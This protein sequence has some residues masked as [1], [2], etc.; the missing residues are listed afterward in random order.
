[1]TR[2]EAKAFIK[3]Q[4]EGY[5]KDKGIDTRRPFNCLNP[6]H[7]DKN[8]SMSLDREHNQAHCFSCGAK[9][10][11][12]DLIGMDNHLDPAR[13]FQRAYERYGI[14]LEGS[15]SPQKPITANK[16]KTPYQESETPPRP[17]TEG[18]NY[19]EY[20]AKCK[21]ALKSSPEALAYLQGRGLTGVSNRL[22][23]D[24]EKKLLI[25]PYDAAGNYYISRSI[26][27]KEYRKAPGQEPLYNAEALYNGSGAVFITEG[28]LD[29]LSII[30]AG[31]EAVA[32]NGTAYTKLLTQLE[33]RRTNNTLIIALDN[34]EAGRAASKKL[35]GELEARRIDYMTVNI[36]GGKKD[37]NE[38]L[39]AD[40][41]QLEGA[42]KDVIEGIEA[43][44]QAQRE[45]EIEEYKQENSAYSHIQAFLEG[46]KIDTPAIPT[47][48]K[49][50]D[51]ALDGGLYEGLYVLG[52]ISSLGKT[53]LVL[54]IAD[55]IAQQGNDVLI[56][57]LEMAR[58]ELMAKSIS[59]ITF[60]GCNGKPSNAK[61]TRGITARQRHE[62]YSTEEKRLINESIVRYG[63]YA[64]N[65]Y[66]SEGAGNI[67]AEEIGEAVRKHISITGKKP[68]VVI[69]YLQILKAA[70]P[71]ST[72]KQN[73]DKA[74]FMLKRIS[75]EYKIPIIGIS[76]LNRDNYKQ[77]INM[78][79]FKESGAIE[80]S[81]DV[82]IG[83][84]FQEVND[85]EISEE[86][87]D[88]EKRKDTR[89]IELK[90]LKNRNGQTGDQIDY[91]FISMFNYFR[92]TGT[93]KETNGR[94]RGK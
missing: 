62:G 2:E 26:T 43:I 91:D 8:P 44:R 76:S 80:Y 90:I 7:Q 93:N 89:K 29:A 58:S 38:A 70:D 48:F 92:E 49:E 28:A 40:R 1:M 88:K 67:G 46:I 66:I 39:V 14:V 15:T 74:V 23:Y 59:R 51:N 72:D 64:K 5:L 75:R 79:A 13:A 4:L 63:E 68:V 31:G 6:A 22:G 65:L 87:L 33:K 56:F 77:K 83:L 11:I 57:S 19:S 24:K 9:Y 35:Q 81:S 60:L 82:L 18:H 53:T 10:D 71:R 47:G 3:P 94:G 21:E 36:S 85:K 16:D 50:L 45:A 78:A 27:G 86:L 37:P 12:F 54:Q 25:I 34:E 32:L 73:T 42:I 84:Q 61:T 17:A 55:Q 41:G 20:I 69:D 30:E 52:A